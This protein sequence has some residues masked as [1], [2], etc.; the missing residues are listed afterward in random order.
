MKASKII[1]GCSIAL[2][3]IF[4]LSSFL[5]EH[6]PQKFLTIRTIEETNGV[7]SKIIILYEDGRSKEVELE[8]FHA[9]NFKSN[10]KKI[11][12]VVNGIASQGYSLVSHS[13]G[14][15]DVLII[16]TYLFVKK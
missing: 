16:G 13:C 12:D 9:K 1:I 8:K 11:H 15:G 2:L 4:L 7:D 6:A 3:S 5:T 14:N 10:S